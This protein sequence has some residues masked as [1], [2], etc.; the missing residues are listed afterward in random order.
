[1]K[2]LPGFLIEAKEWGIALVHGVL[3]YGLIF[4]LHAYIKAG[5]EY[6]RNATP[7]QRAAYNYVIGA[8]Y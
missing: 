3:A 4:A 1:M 8:G 2:K 6:N 7:K 5:D